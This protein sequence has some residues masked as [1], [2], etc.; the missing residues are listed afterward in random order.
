MQQENNNGKEDAKWKLLVKK[1]LSAKTISSV[2]LPKRKRAAAGDAMSADRIRS[3][4]LQSV[5][6]NRSR[7]EIRT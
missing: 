2:C 1:V 5:E 4:R 3:F 6:Q 7:L